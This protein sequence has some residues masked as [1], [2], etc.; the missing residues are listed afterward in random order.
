M[1]GFIFMSSWN[2]VLG[3]GPT[4]GVGTKWNEMG[5]EARTTKDAVLGWKAHS[6]P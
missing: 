4:G 1:V 3:T 6:R 2:R 5:L